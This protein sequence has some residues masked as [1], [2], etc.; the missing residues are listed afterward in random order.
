M[1][2]NISMQWSSWTCTYKFEGLATHCFKYPWATMATLGQVSTARQS[3]GS[4]IS[5]GV[6]N[7]KCITHTQ[8]DYR[9][10]LRSLKVKV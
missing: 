1:L 10:I 3:A 8:M 6:G 2:L 7:F 5:C 9:D 4:V